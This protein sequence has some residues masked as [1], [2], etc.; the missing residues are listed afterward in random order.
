[1]TSPKNAPE[2][3]AKAW[4]T[5][6]ERYG[7]RGHNS[8]YARPYRQT[9]CKVCHKLL[10]ALVRLHI[11]GTLSEGQASKI[12]GC[13]RVTLRAMADEITNAMTQPEAPARSIPLATP[14]S[15]TRE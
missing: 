10:T 5:R 11:D 8:S 6:R 15:S 2:V 7:E 4:K 1:M 14:T 3:R 12:I 13:D 9:E